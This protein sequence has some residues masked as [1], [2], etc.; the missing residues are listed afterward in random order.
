M[1]SVE[2]TA[3]FL[4][5]TAEFGQDIVDATNG[6]KDMIDAGHKYKQLE[7]AL[8]AG[9]CM[10]LP[11]NIGESNWTKILTKGTERHRSVVHNLSLTTIA[12][13][14]RQYAALRERV[15]STKLAELQ[16]LQHVSPSEA[17]P[18]PSQNLLEGLH[19]GNWSDFNTNLNANYQL[20]DGFEFGS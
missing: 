7:A 8:G 20:F 4:H 2:A 10:F 1:P 6:L 16:S 11:T 14:A 17:A 15:V 13:F 3:M 12:P 5:H 9:V 19:Q 18:G